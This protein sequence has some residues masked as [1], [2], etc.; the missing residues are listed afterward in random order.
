MNAYVTANSQTYRLRQRVEEANI[1]HG[2]EVR[3]DLPNVRVTTFSSAPASWFD[4]IRGVDPEPRA[5]VFF[6]NMGSIAI[7]EVLETGDDRPLPATVILEG[8]AVSESGI[9]DLRNALVKSNG[10]LR[11]VVDNATQVVPVHRLYEGSPV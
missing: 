1:R 3:A 10:D 2:Q 9:Y 6:C 8:L 4:R 7:R 11:V 5:E